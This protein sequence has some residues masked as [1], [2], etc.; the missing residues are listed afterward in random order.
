MNLVFATPDLLGYGGIQHCNQLAVRA[1]REWLGGEG[2]VHVLSRMDTTEAMTAAF[3]PPCFGAGGSRL[4]MAARLLRAVNT[5]GCDALLLMHVNLAPLLP[6]CLWRVPILVMMYGLD[7]W[8]PLPRAARWG[9]RRA[10]RLVSI[11]EHTRRTAEIHNPWM[12]DARHS[13]C[14]LGV[15]PAPEASASVIRSPEPAPYALTIGRMV[16]E[17]RYKGFDEMLAVWPRLHNERPGLKLVLIGDGPD[18]SNLEAKA[19]RVGAN[20]RFLGR[21]DD[22]TRDHYL[23]HCLAFCM[24]SRSEGFGL[25]Y[26]E[27]MR[28]GRAVL[29]GCSDAGAEVLV[30]GI[31]GRAVDPTNADKLLAALLD[32]TGPNA[33]A[34]GEAGR[35]RFL[36]QFTYDHFRKRLIAEVRGLLS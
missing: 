27:A 33:G 32:V 2:T 10:T 17:E 12:K 34:Y 19:R 14:Y 36:E 23:R 9:L 8:R 7:V 29:A 20:A 16:G 22:V 3:G 4:R 21:V 26:L 25:V 28:L 31:T 5:K 13:I 15:P 1:L 24:P 18:R 30:D 6:L 35:Q 11:S